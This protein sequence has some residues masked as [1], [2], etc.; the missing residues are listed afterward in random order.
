MTRMHLAYRLSL[1]VLLLAAACRDNGATTTATATETTGTGS[2]SVEP[3]TST[4]AEPTTSTTIEPTG[5][6]GSSSTG[7]PAPVCSE[8][9]SE[10]D[11]VNADCKWTTVVNY[12]HGTQGCQGNVRDFCVPKDT[13][14]G[15]TA[16]WRDNGGDIEVV[17]FPFEPTDLGPEWQT[18]D[19]AGPLACLCTPLPLDCPDRL[20]EFCGTIT[21]ENGCENALVAGNLACGWFSVSPEGPAD[22]M[23]TGDPQ[24]NRCLPATGVGSMTC[25]PISLPY[26][27]CI[28]WTTPVYWRDNGGVIEVT[29]SCGPE[30][31]GWTKCVADDPNQPEECKCRCL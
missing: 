3:T 13:S 31:T 25:D 30:P 24:T 28:S 2:T 27:N 20:E 18:C 8:Q 11:C 21:G 15:L 22:T 1:G 26:P 6:T 5:S 10:A 7:E 23:C 14:G 29:P 19:C 4:T 12:T 9:K 16:V 17:Q